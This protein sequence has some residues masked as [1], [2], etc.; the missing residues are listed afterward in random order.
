VNKPYAQFYAKIISKDFIFLLK[1]KRLITINYSI[2]S[3]N[4]IWTNVQN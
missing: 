2:N 3:N 1:I 4:K